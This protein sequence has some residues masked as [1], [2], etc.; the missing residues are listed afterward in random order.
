MSNLSDIGFPVRGDE[1]V[2]EM[3]QNV[4]QYVKEVPCLNGFYYVFTDDSGAE[5]YLQANP[6][7]ELIG[8]N[9][10]FAGKSRRK[11]SITAK[12]ERDSS[13]L[14][15]GFKAWAEPKEENNPESGE[16]PFVFDAPDFRTVGKI[17]F[18][19][20]FEMQLTAFASNEFHIYESEQ[21][22]FDSQD[23]EIKFAAKS[24]VPSGLFSVDENAPHA[25]PRPFGIFT[26]EI[27][28]F[29]LKTNSLTGEKFYWFLV[30]TLGGEVDVVADVKLIETE[31]KIGGIL[32]GQFWLSG[33]IIDPPSFQG[34]RS[35]FL[36][37]LNQ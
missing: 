36:K 12:I 28:E 23:S 22:Y 37:V 11:V 16:Y 19:Q 9:P 6:G 31:P 14:D 8:F 1:D 15:G 17:K 5:M 30:E 34:M 7:Q 26:G 2:N 3:I 4:A 27:K 35:R 13:E 25:A 20:E 29:E 18:P 24:F 33:K 21:A 32:N 10:H